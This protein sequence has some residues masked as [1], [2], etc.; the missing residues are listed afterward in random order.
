MGFLNERT[1]ETTTGGAAVSDVLLIAG[2][3]WAWL[4]KNKPAFILTDAPHNILAMLNKFVERNKLAY[5]NA[6][7][8]TW[9]TGERQAQKRVEPYR[10]IVA[11]F[12]DADTI[13]DPF[14]GWGPVALAALREGRNFVGVE[15]KADRVQ[16][17]V[18]QIQLAHPAARLHVLGL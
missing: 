5:V 1:V 18:E 3:A 15:H 12:P 10:Q 4:E 9:L 8:P 14:M 16:Y 11:A 2:D 7:S 6:T 17:V 13:C